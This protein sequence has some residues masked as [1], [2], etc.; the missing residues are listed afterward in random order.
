METTTSLGK[1]SNGCNCRWCRATRDS[2]K[3]QHRKRIVKHIHRGTFNSVPSLRWNKKE[4][5]LELSTKGSRL[6]NM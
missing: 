6:W 2:S 4:G 3:D 5:K 1:M